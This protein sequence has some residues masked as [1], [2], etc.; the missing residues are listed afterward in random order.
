MK[1]SPSNSH[2]QNL[3]I[4]SHQDKRNRLRP[5]KTLQLLPASQR[6]EHSH[7]RKRNPQKSRQNLLQQQKI[8]K[9]SKKQM[10]TC[11]RIIS[12]Q[13][14]HQLRN[15]LDLVLLHL[16]TYSQPKKVRLPISHSTKKKA[17]G[18]SKMKALF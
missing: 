18:S 16:R 13:K 7:L 4:L 1:R 8:L 17:L 3:R 12:S 9:V 5:T 15:R 2:N 11:L 6:K 14:E 10:E